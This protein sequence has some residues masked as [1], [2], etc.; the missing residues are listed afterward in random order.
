MRRSVVVGFGLVMIVEKLVVVRIVVVCD[1]LCI[2]KYGGDY[3]KNE[4]QR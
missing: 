1:A 3:K 2:Y 4:G